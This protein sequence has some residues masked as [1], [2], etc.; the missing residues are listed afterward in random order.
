VFSPSLAKAGVTHHSFVRRVG[1]DGERG[2]SHKVR[3]GHSPAARLAL[4]AARR[5]PRRAA[6][7]AP[8]AATGV[9]S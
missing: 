9:C 5:I 1:R 7:P 6:F 3:L 4:S 8:R 2:V